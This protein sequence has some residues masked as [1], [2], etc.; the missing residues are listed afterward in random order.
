MER[1]LGAIHEGVFVMEDITRFCAALQGIGI[2]ARVAPRGRPEEKVGAEEC[3]G[4]IDIQDGPI[5]WI[6]L[7]G[8]ARHQYPEYGIPD[9]TVRDCSRLFI[10]TRRVKS[11]PFLGKVVGV[12]W[13]GVDK[14]LGIIDSLNKNS[15][16]NEALLREPS[17][18]APG[19]LIQCYS[20]HPCWVISQFLKGVVP[21]RELWSCYQTIARHLLP[22]NRGN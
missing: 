2:D 17:M 15:L 9:P 8:G 22:E 20:W 21:S 18:Q 3:L 5:R 12:R 14:G 13:K 6:T 11:F 10:T 4:V 16:L 7:R 1:Y 19:L